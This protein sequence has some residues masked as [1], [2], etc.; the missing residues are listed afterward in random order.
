MLVSA[1]ESF[2]SVG[3]SLIGS[4]I[5]YFIPEEMIFLGPFRN[6]QEWFDIWILTH[7][8]QKIIEENLNLGNVEERA[9]RL[10]KQFGF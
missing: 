8:V 5:L 1:L 7:G 3:F 6:L 2:G 10:V 4:R 9:A